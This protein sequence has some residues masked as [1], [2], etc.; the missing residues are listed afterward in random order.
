MARF[1][2]VDLGGTNEPCKALKLR[3]LGGWLGMLLGILL[4]VGFSR[5]C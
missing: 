4:V 2:D 3:M 5:N 1:C